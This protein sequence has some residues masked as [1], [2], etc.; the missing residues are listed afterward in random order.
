MPEE[1]PLQASRSVGPVPLLFFFFKI[2]SFCNSSIQGPVTPSG[3]D[4]HFLVPF[5]PRFVI[6]NTAYLLWHFFFFISPGFLFCPF[7]MP[8]AVGDFF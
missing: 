6:D 7:F 8:V 5:F 3:F 4:P 2:F 1:L